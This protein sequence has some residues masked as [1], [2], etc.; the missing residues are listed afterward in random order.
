MSP[1]TRQVDIHDATDFADEYQAELFET[2][3]KSGENIGINI[4]I[5]IMCL[6]LK[7]LGEFCAYQLE[8]SAL[9]VGSMCL[10]LVC[11]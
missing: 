10:S 6:F 1:R 9:S 2:S 8:N 11:W 7:V 3:S 5:A 4:T